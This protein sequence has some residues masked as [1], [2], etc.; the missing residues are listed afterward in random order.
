MPQRGGRRKKYY[1]IEKKGAELL[2]Y[3]YEAQQRIARGTTGRLEQLLKD[4]TA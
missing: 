2:H 1:R 4:P 3:T